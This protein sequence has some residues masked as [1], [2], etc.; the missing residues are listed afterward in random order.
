MKELTLDQF[1]TW[2]TTD[3]LVPPELISHLRAIAEQRM[4]LVAIDVAMGNL[5]TTV[6]EQVAEKVF[7]ALQDK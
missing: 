2:L 3:D 5:N 4:E 6:A 1:L 7:Y